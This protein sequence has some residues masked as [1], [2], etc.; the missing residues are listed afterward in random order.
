[1]A[2]GELPHAFRL[3][4]KHIALGVELAVNIAY[5]ADEAVE[6]RDG[7]ALNIA[8]NQQSGFDVASHRQTVRAKFGFPTLLQKTG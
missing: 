4:C 7:G 2:K 3:G 1:M 6:A 5:F 8:P